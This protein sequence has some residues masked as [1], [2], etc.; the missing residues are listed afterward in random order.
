M[1]FENLIVQ[2]TPLLLG[3]GITLL[4]CCRDLC[5]ILANIKLQLNGYLKVENKYYQ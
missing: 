5:D 1:L 3:A 2:S 4:I